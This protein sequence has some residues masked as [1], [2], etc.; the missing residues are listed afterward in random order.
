MAN[1]KISE[2]TAVTALAGTDVFPVVD[3]SAS[4]T[5][6]V[7][8]TDLLRNAPAGT[9]GAPGIANA[10]DQDTGILF[11]AANSIGV[12]TGG[13]QRLVIDS[14]GNVGVGTSSPS[15]AF[16]ISKPLPIVTLQDSDNTGNAALQRIDAKHSGGS[17]QWF[18]GKNSTSNADLYIQNVSNAALRFGTNNTERLRIDNSGQ[19]GIGTT[20]P[21]VLL[22]CQ[23]TGSQTIRARTNDTSGTAVGI[24][25]AEYAGGGGGTNSNVEI[26][27]GDGYSFI[28]NTTNSPM[29]F[30]INDSERM[31]IDSSGRLL[32][33]ASSS[34]SAGSSAAA[35]LQV[36]HAGGNVTGAFYCTAN[37]TQGGTLVLGHGRGS[38]TGVLQSGDT[39]GDIRFAGADGAD[40]V[41]QGAK[42]AA[43][44]DGTPGSNDM[45]GRII[46][47][48]NP[49]GSGNSPTER[50]RI[51]TNGNVQVNV[52]QFTVGTTASTGLQFINDGTF[53]TLHSSPLVFRTVSAERMRIDTSGNVAIGTTSADRRLHV[54][55]TNGT[56]AHF[57][58][59]NAN[60]IA[61]VV[62]EGNGVS[63]PPNLGATGEN[64]HFTTGNIERMRID[65]SGK[66]LLGTT[67][68]YTPS[69]GG[70]TPVTVV[71][72]GNH[73]ANLVISNQTNHADAGAAVILAAHGQDWQLEATSVLKGNRDFTIKA[74]TNE[75]LRLDNSGRFLYGTT[76][77]VNLNNASGG[78]AREAKAYI[79]NTASTTSERYNLGLI[80]GNNGVAGP[81]VFL[82]KTRASSNTHTVVQSGDETGDIR[83]S[84]SDGTFFIESAR[85]RAKVD[86]TPGSQDMPGRLEFHTT[87]DGASSTTEQMR[88]DS[89]GRVGIGTTDPGSFFAGADQLVVS[90][91]SGDGGITID[92]GTSAIGRFLFADGTSGADQYRGYLAYGHSANFLTIGTDGSERMRIDSSGR[93]GI[94]VSTMS[95]GAGDVT[96]IRNSAL[97]W[98]DSDGTQRADIYG[99][100]SSNIV[101]RNGTSSTERMRITDDGLFKFSNTGAYT[102]IDSG[103]HGFRQGTSGNWALE[104]VHA[105]TSGNIYGI[106]SQFSSYAPNNT[107]SWF[108]LGSDSSANRFIVYSNGGIANYQ[109]NN[110]NLC[111]EREKKNIEALDSTWDCLKHWD[112]K[113]FHY[114]EDADT[115]D[116]RYGVIAQQVA[117][118]CPEVISDWVKQKAKDAVLDDDGNVVTP[119][120]E[121]VT[122]MAVKEQQMMWMAIKAL[123]EAQTRIETL[124]AKVAA[125]EAQ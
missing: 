26:R 43:E 55:S 83:F 63:T 20:S 33:G 42:I 71:D 80:T 30:G 37:S 11:P 60:T 62:F 125:L 54:K 87:A 28:N 8:V 7:S 109:S 2:L 103:A 10:D 72:G 116:K 41:T 82:S 5:N 86:G 88:I 93:V 110:A 122:R 15:T 9:A 16:H 105:A 115:D 79:Y 12:S 99:D 96:I 90:G 57:E 13:A 48:T 51:D 6:K 97:R 117:E 39:L 89:S 35:M 108:Y 1:T 19:V 107:S 4:T 70:S 21:N 24:L 123:Q 18:I 74:G 118:H 76:T 36:E 59:S 50:M 56:V 66:L 25:R 73:R 29:L 34:V 23:G 92:S 22:D 78:S 75:R 58:S 53:G 81:T 113:R 17:T 3:V 68:V 49:G 120:V 104:V 100:S 45:P 46:F 102:S 38:A 112:L 106:H 14:S 31:R 47:S 91:G 121:E 85:I 111:D 101:F 124:E 95:G 119:A 114:N 44:V 77:G 69:G 52:G 27:A 67:T 98:A 94:G 64:L 40:L 65:S 84:G 61:Q 32:V